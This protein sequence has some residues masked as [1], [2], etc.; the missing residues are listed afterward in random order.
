MNVLLQQVP[1]LL[2]VVTGA[3]ITFLLAAAGE[4][5]RWRRDQATRW[6]A[7]RMQTYADYA[8]AVKRVVHVA[9]RMAAARGLRHSSEPIAIEEG[10]VQLALA[11]QALA[12]HWE[13]V[14]LLGDRATIE[15]ARTWHQCVWQLEFY[16]RGHLD[17]ADG[18]QAALDAFERTR[19]EF[20]RCARRD[21]GLGS[22]DVPPGTVPAWL[23]RYFDARA[24]AGS[25]EAGR[26]DP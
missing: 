24:A 6:D 20:Y 2:G 4:R 16:A 21:L 23:E 7:A 22:V 5:A 8:D 26:T 9:T 13:R 25:D 14:L 3:A 15:A 19:A 18:W 1:A 11:A 17:G 12:T 10:Q